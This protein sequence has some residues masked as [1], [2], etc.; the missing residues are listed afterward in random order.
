MHLLRRTAHDDRN[1]DDENDAIDPEL[2]LRTVRTAH[3]TLEESIRTEERAHR[4]RTMMRKRSKGFF[5]RGIDKKRDQGIAES[6]SGEQSTAPAITGLRRNIYVNVPLPQDELDSHG[7]PIVRY[8]RN[9]IR[10]SSEC[11]GGTQWR[12][13]LTYIQSTLSLLSYLE[14]SSNSFAGK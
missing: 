3:S 2:R 12:R 5:R 14:T 1:T 4:R 7:E 8:A 13:V 11:P 6:Q 9:K 10:T